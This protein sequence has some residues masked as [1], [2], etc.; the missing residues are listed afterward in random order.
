MVDKEKKK[1]DEKLG[2]R[3]IAF[4]FIG[5]IIQ[6]KL[7][8]LSVIYDQTLQDFKKLQLK[9]RISSGLKIWGSFKKF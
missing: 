9:V 7:I 2:I 3:V 6:L 8:L 4:Y 5:Q 1:R